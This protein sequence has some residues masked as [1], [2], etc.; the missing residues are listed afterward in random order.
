AG[1][2]T[3]EHGYGGTAEVFELM[4]KQG[5]AF[6]PTL[7]ADEAYSEYFRGYKRGTTPYTADMEQALRA[8]KLAL[9]KGVTVGCGS[10]V[11][12][13]AHGESWREVEWMVKGGMT[14]AQALA[15]TTSVTAKVL[16]EQDR[17]GRVA[18]GLLA[19][20]IAVNGDPTRDI[21]VLRSVPFVMKGG[22]IYKKPGM[23]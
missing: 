18:P 5:V 10:D 23:K 3:I 9:A 4:A 22:T 7:T 1:V 21:T 8:F 6:Y 19:D 14:P 11:G 16:G 20:L 15:A 12:V 2:D 17:L 13:F